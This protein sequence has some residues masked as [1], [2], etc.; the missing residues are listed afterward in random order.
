MKSKEYAKRGLQALVGLFI[1]AVG[2]YL[3]LHANVGVSPW[4][5]LHVGLSRVLSLSYGTVSVGFALLIVVV[6][7][8]VLHER[9][10]FGTIMDALVVGKFVDLLEWL[11]LVPQCQRFLPGLGMLFLGMTII[12]IGQWLYMATGLGC[13]PRDAFLVGIGRHMPRLPIGAVSF[14]IFA[15]VTVVG[16]LLRGGVGVG[17]LLFAVFQSAI[18]QLV[19][20][21]A[22]F[23]PRQVEHEDIVQTLQRLKKKESA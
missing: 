2:L 4:D 17:T 7:L 3:T 22:R 15:A 18:M 19:F 9:I 8:F 12:S 10:G 1:C 16:F 21:I 20:R 13:G 6:D 23:E 5:T 11:D 14:M